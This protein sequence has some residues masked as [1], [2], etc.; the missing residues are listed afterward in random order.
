[1]IKS[2]GTLRSEHLH[3]VKPIYRTAGKIHVRQ[4]QNGVPLLQATRTEANFRRTKDLQFVA[5]VYG[6]RVFH[7]FIGISAPV[8][9]EFFSFILALLQ[10]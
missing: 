2:C 1:M 7:R 4:S 3:S 8:S 6:L 5:L 10:I 9:S